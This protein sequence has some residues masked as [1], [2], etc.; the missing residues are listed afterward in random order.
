MMSHPLGNVASTTRD[1][2]ASAVDT[3]D[4]GTRMTPT[5]QHTFMDR[6]LRNDERIAELE[7]QITGMTAL[8]ERALSRRGTHAA[9]RSG[10]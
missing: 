2:A 8:V 6:L 7:R 3:G 5:E 1:E 10:D 9:P 4:D